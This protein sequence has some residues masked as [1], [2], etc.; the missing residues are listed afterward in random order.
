VTCFFVERGERRKGVSVALLEACVRFVRDQGGEWVE[1]YPV[2]P[3]KGELPAA[4]A[5][6]GTASAFR[7]AG[8]VEAARGAATRP[9]MRMKV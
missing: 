8:F 6:T 5:W 7:Q 4:F 9:I 2:E 3:G 1:G